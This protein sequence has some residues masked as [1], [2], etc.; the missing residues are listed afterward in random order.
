MVSLEIIKCLLDAASTFSSKGG[1]ELLTQRDNNGCTPLHI[2]SRCFFFDKTI[3]VMKY[4]FEFCKSY[5]NDVNDRT[6]TRTCN[7]TN[8]CISSLVLI[9]DN[10]GELPI[11]WFVRSFIRN[12]GN[13]VQIDVF[14]ILLEQ[15]MKYH[16]TGNNNDSNEEEYVMGGLFLDIDNA[17]KSQ[18]ILDA[19]L[20]KPDIS[21]D[22]IVPSIQD[23]I[24]QYRLYHNGIDA[25]IIQAAII[26]QV[27][28][29][30]LRNIIHTF[31]QS[32]LTRNSRGLLPIEIAIEHQ[33]MWD[34]GMK[35][36]IEVFTAFSSTLERRMTIHI[37][38]AYG[39]KWECGMKDIIEENVNALDEID[40][41]T[42]LYPFALAATAGSK[43]NLK[44]I[45][46]LMY[47]RRDT[48][49]AAISNAID[50][51]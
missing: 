21:W 8:A 45:Y 4:L 5:D 25:P 24:D 29:E 32:I 11:H 50:H 20:M 34:K 44:S 41:L 16:L 26:T 14:Q 48:A 43:T 2:L 51:E 47:Y 6:H 49:I 28:A 13:Y 27:S 23:I 35:E 38:A 7:D 36:I 15:G 12:I 3:E 33:L 19:L 17:M 22:A 40:P 18:T 1:I 46:A 39:L 10:N 42:G 30:T 9:K 31:P 37:G